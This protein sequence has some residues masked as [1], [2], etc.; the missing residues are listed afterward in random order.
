MNDDWISL[1][2][3]CKL[4]G[5]SRPTLNKLR[6]NKKLKEVRL[7]GK[8]RL[9]KLDILRKITLKLNQKKELFNLT[10]FGGFNA[11]QIQ[12]MPGIYD[13]RTIESID[14]YGV[15]ALLCS[16][17]FHL[18]KNENN[19]VYLLLDASYP[20]SYLDSIGFFTEVERTHKSR[21]F[22]NLD[23]I[24]KYPQSSS[25]V[26][27]PL[28]L[29]GYRGAE[30]KIL[31]Q[32]YE[33]LLT[34]GFSETYCGYI[35]WVIGELCDNAHTHS[36]GPCYLIIE[37]LQRGS[38]ETRF[39]L[40]AIGDTGIGIP[41]SLQK[42]PKYQTTSSKRLLPMSFMSEVSRMEAEPSRGKGLS[43]VIAVGKGND[44]WFRVDSNG[45]GV[46]FDFRKQEDQINYTKPIVMA[47][48]T[49]FCLVLIDS[50]LKKISRKE[51][52][53]IVQSFLDGSSL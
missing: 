49:R 12:P 53:N 37:S 13:L 45:F 3:A 29:I 15:M 22:A 40:I 25:T 24:K 39:L 41:A 46:S 18:K 48:G 4:L 27:L 2:G 38:T 10:I 16:I 26:I 11:D 33:S 31:D 14:A 51:T 8:I 32:L 20:C 44:S 19:N 7:S 23:A 21:V 1:A 28:H 43:D 30:K 5:I 17:K 42:N 36:E 47:P 34:Q 50:E 6:T 9:S 35:G 52:N